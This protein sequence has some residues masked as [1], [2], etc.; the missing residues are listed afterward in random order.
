MIDRPRVLI[1]WAKPTATNLGIR[2]LAEGAVALCRTAWP[3]CEIVMHDHD[4]EGSPLGKSAIFSD[5]GRRNGYIKK[6]ARGFDFVLDTGSGDSFT[7]IYGIR[8]LVV[9]GYAQNA[10]IRSRTPLIIMPQ[11]LGPFE[12]RLGQYVG[13]RCLRNATRVFSRDSQSAEYSESLGRIVDAISSDVV[14]ML[15]Q[16]EIKSDADVIINVSGLLWNENPHVNNE[17]YRESSVRLVNELLQQGRSVTLLAHVLK[18]DISA[19]GDVQ[20]VDALQKSLGPSR[21][22]SVFIPESLNDVRSVM[23]GAN[24]VVGAR[25]HACLNALSVGTP[26]VP[27]AYSRK[28]APLLEDI[29]WPYVVDLREP[30]DH[31][32][33]TLGHLG[34]DDLRIHAHR[35][36][37]KAKVDFG[38]VI[39]SM[40]STVE[41]HS[42]SSAK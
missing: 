24:V 34:Q 21:G 11:T 38:N 39:N 4:T 5:I 25:M 40:R 12:S 36:A 2:A 31:V 8:R 42:N 26:A 7:D 35:C 30:V 41:S 33:A 10:V 20:A 17:A 19:E 16:P 23:A 18:S 13:K 27:W 32:A 22:V 29:G 37:G 14:F 28:F 9:M 6:M 1:L 15:E 3:N